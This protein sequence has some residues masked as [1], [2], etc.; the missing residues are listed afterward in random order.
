MKGIKF[1]QNKCKIL[2][3]ASHKIEIENEE[4]ENKAKQQCCS[5]WPGIRIGHKP[6]RS[7]QHC[8]MGLEGI[9]IWVSLNLPR[10]EQRD[11]SC[12]I[13]LLGHRDT[14]DAQP[15]PHVH[16][17]RT[18]FQ[19]LSPTWHWY[20]RLFLPRCRISHLPLLN[21]IRFLSILRELWSCHQHFSSFWV[22]S[23][24]RQYTR[25]HAKAV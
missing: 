14:P 25:I 6:D 13:S 4:R 12:A 23:F 21:P 24:P 3:L 5:E 15:R 9:C 19:Q 11:P 2:L 7:Q 22:N 16:L 20:T 10:A 8:A 1:N 17:C 18:P